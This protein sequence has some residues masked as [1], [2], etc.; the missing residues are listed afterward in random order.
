M[1]I[2]KKILILF[3]LFNKFLLNNA[4]ALLGVEALFQVEINKYQNNVNSY[5]L[6]IT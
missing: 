3:V 4:P 2:K 1:F 5:E 6:K